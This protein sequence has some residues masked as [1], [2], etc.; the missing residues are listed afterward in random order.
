M[1]ILEKINNKLKNA[2]LDV[3]QEVLDFV[4]FLEAKRR[5]AATK[6]EFKDF[7]GALKDSLAFQGDPVE[8][9]RTLRSEWDRD[10]I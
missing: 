1:T 10:Q 6:R 2:P 9:Q 8:I 3:A 4:E 5:R 7:L